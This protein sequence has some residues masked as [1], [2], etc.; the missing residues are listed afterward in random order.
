MFSDFLM[1]AKGVVSLFG[2]AVPK[3]VLKFYNALLEK[4][5][6]TAIPLA[7]KFTKL[8]SYITAENE[9]AAL[10]ATAE[11]GGNKAG[12]PRSPYQNLDAETL[13]VF[14]KILGELA[15]M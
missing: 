12:K 15:E 11:I 1:G 3:I 4:D 14:K 5:L 9:V 10:K 13:V 2:I 7:H 8:S 6:A